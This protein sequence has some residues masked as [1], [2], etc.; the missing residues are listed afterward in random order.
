MSEIN[1]QGGLFDP[2]DAARVL[3]VR[4]PHAWLLIHGS[5]THGVKD[6]ENRSRPTTHRGALLIQAS[7]EVD[8]A[9]YADYVAQGVELP[10]VGELVTGAII[11]RVDLVGCVRDATSAWALPG[12]CHWL[13][14]S[15]QAAREPI[16]FKGQLAMSTPPAGWQDQF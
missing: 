15:P 1:Y 5:P 14:A 10:P 11:G 9:A 4:Q 8:R 7:A 3:T 12:H 16:P 13:T 2:A 6:V